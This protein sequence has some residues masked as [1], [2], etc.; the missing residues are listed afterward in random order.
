MPR[1]TFY[2]QRYALI[3]TKARVLSVEGE[4]QRAS[5]PRTGYFACSNRMYNRI[6]ELIV[7]AIESN[8]Q[9]VFTDCPHREKLGWLEETHLIGP[10]ILANFDA[11][12]LYE[13]ILDDM[14]DAQ[15]PEG[16]VPDIAPEFV[17]FDLGFRDS[18]E[19]GSACVLVPWYL[20]QKYADRSIL[21]KHFAMG[22]RYAAYL[23]GKTRDG[24]LNH[25]LGDWLDVGHYPAHPANTPIPITATAILLQDLLVLSKAAD[26]LGL[27]EKAASYREKAEACKKAFNDWFFY[28]LSKNYATGSQTANAFALYLDV[29]PAEY[30]ARVEENLRFDIDARGGHFTGGDIGHPYLLRALAKCGMNDVIAENFMKTDFPSYGYQ[31]VCNATTLCEDWDGPNPEH[32]V[33]SQN[34][35][36]LGAAEEWFYQVLAGIRVNACDPIH[37]E[38]YF[39]EQADWVDCETLTPCGQ[40][41]VRWQREAEGHIRVTVSL[42]RAGRILLCLGGREELLTVEGDIERVV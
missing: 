31:V 6:H 4:A 32:P 36:M 14:E 2:G 24:V 19:W 8:M 27:A 23:F 39:A 16:L 38:P 9:S 28:P 42:E 33:M 11:R 30:R 22:E 35:F 41:R 10:G 7:G 26:V 5:C 37:I 40:C 12:A 34:H 18:P 20:Y 29:P 13:K 1:F 25:G 17:R 3:D 21:E 15:T